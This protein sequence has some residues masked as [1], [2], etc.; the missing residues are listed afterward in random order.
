MAE[1]M[2]LEVHC[3]QADSE[4]K[5]IAQGHGKLSIHFAAELETIEIILRVNCLC[6]PAQSLRI[7][8]REM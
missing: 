6:K 8:R 4:A 7:S 3:P 5:D 1:R 2:L